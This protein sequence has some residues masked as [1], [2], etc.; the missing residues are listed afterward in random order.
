MS[1]TAK[2]VGSII[3]LVI[4]F[5]MPL[6]LY[7]YQFGFG[8]WENH[9]E[10]A[11]MGSALSGIYSPIIAL[12]AFIILVGQF[13]SQYTMNKFHFDQSFIQKSQEEL[14]FYIE[15]LDHYLNDESEKTESVRELLRR[16]SALSEAELRSDLGKRVVQEFIGEHRKIHDIWVAI[17]PSLKGLGVHDHYPYVNSYQGSK[18]KLM[19]VLSLN[20]CIALDKVYFSSNSKIDRGEA[21]VL[22]PGTHITSDYGCSSSY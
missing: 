11:E 4:L 2:I 22:G 3:F 16:F 18:V 13:F 1:R 8:I 5:C 21:Q 6:A 12:L 7:A 20:T 9:G 17:Y 15:Q 19:A 14:N 10:W